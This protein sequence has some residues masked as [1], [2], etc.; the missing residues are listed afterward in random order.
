MESNLDHQ[1][2]AEHDRQF[3]G[4][5]RYSRI[6]ATPQVDPTAELRQQRQIERETD[7]DNRGAIV[8]NTNHQM[9]YSRVDTRD[10]KALAQQ[11]AECL[12]LLQ[13]YEQQWRKLEA[14][15]GD[16]TAL[17]LA[18]QYA[19]KR[20]TELLEL[21]AKEPHE[22]NGSDQTIFWNPLTAV[23]IQSTLNGQ[24]P[25]EAVYS[26]AAPGDTTDPHLSSWMLLQFL[27]P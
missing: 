6:P 8:I 27:L 26:K 4:E 13:N 18:L 9:E 17:R 16:K 5:L 25:R 19:H 2:Q 7:A 15:P 1:S 11:I 21:Q 3:L 23:L 24:E 20:L 10:Q 12:E 22:F 14:F